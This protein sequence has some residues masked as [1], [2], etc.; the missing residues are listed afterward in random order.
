MG[1]TPAGWAALIGTEAS[2]HDQPRVRR[3]RAVRQATARGRRRARRG[4]RHRRRW[5]P[6][7]ERAAARSDRA[8]PM[9]ARLRFVRQVDAWLASAAIRP[10]STIWSRRPACRAARSSASA[11]R[12]TAPRPSCSRANIAPCA[13]RWRWPRASES[14][15]DVIERGFYDQSHLI[16][17]IKQF[18]GLTPRQI[19]AEPPLLSRL[20]IAQR[21]ALGGAG[22]SADQRHLTRSDGGGLRRHLPVGPIQPDRTRPSWQIGTDYSDPECASTGAHAPFQPCRLCGRD[23]VRRRAPLRR[24]GAAERDAACRARPACRCRPRRS[25]SAACRPPG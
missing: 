21:H 13:P 12:S 15:D 20:T 10:R 18:T 3:R 11:T 23:D 5:S 7:A 1:I 24:R 25:W 2:T 14:V 17:E 19:R 6:I 16:R 8:R 4:A 9:A 22:Q